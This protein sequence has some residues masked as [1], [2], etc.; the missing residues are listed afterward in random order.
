MTP[1][2][3]LALVAC[4][5]VS[6][7]AVAERRLPLALPILEQSTDVLGQPVVYPEGPARISSVIITL[8]PGAET[9]WHS[10]PVPLYGHV[11][12]GT[13]TVDYGEK[14]VR[15]F[16]AGEAL[17][18][19]VNWPHNGSNRG[20]VPVKILAVSI[21]SKGRPNSMPATAPSTPAAAR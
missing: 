9:G 11:L 3:M 13:L 4:L 1:H 21:G 15:E 14:G 8:A 7:A 12:E 20:E 2:H 19:A 17:L 18:E 6:S 5:L 10:H 16:K